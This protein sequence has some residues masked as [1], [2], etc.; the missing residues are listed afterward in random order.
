[1][2]FLIFNGSVYRQDEPVIAKALQLFY[3]GFGLIETLLYDAQRIPLWIGHGRRIRAS[4]EQLCWR[5]PDRFLAQVSDGIMQLIMK[6]E[7]PDKAKIKLQMMQ[8]DGQIQFMLEAVPM[9][10][11]R[12]ELVIGIARNLIK[13]VSDRSFMKSNDRRIFN[14]TIAQAKERCLADLLLLNSKGRIV[15]STIANVFWENNNR[16]FTPPLSEGCIAGVLRDALLT[17]TQV[18]KGLKVTEKELTIEDALNADALY[19]G[20]ALRGLRKVKELVI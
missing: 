9:P 8:S 12:G 14:E 19:L 18:Y 15:E 13:E 7:L 20:N 10:E 17:G 16:L 4:F 2:A 6:N 5:L 1:M 11:S 3:S